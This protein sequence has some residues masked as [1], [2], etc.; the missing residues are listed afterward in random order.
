MRTGLGG[1]K[2]GKVGKRR[3]EAPQSMKI[4]VDGYKK[5]KT[6]VNQYVLES[7]TEQKIAPDGP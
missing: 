5:G 2:L 7:T 3:L 1:L 4:G 6:N